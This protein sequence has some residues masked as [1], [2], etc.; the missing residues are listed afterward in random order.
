MHGKILLLLE[1]IGQNIQA[2]NNEASEH[3]I[4]NQ[5]LL[6]QLA[7]VQVTVEK[8]IDDAGQVQDAAMKAE[9]RKNVFKMLKWKFS[10]LHFPQTLP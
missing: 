4:T 7:N 6:T 10:N 2:N 9:E 1:V 8:F 3:D 5:E